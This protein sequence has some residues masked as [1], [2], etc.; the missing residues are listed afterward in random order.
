MNRGRNTSF[1]EGES[2]VTTLPLRLFKHCPKRDLDFRR[3]DLEHG[4]TYDTDRIRL[5]IESPGSYSVLVDMQAFV[6]SPPDAICCT[7]WLNYLQVD[8]QNPQ[9]ITGYCW[10]G[11]QTLLPPA[12]ENLMTCPDFYYLYKK[13]VET[14]MADPDIMRDMCGI[15]ALIPRDKLKPLE[16]EV[17]S[18][19][20]KT[21]Q[22][23]ILFLADVVQ[24]KFTMSSDIPAFILAYM[25]EQ[26]QQP[27]DDLRIALTRA[28]TSVA[29][30]S[31]D[32]TDDL[33]AAGRAEYHAFLRAIAESML[34]VAP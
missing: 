8:S 26:R 18:V 3:V 7:R 14:K 9:H 23:C 1:L 2:L 21:F 24:K 30:S 5:L 15:C 20:F 33:D 28:Y 12:G 27:N 13:L 22:T 31:G 29:G 4:S 25:R 19:S 10:A 17:H 16:S 11:G 34:I 6:E 32:E